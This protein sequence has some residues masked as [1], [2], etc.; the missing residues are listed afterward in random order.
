MVLKMNTARPTE[1]DA[2]V[3][4]FFSA[5][6]NR[7]GRVPDFDGLCAM[8]SPGAVVVSHNG[9]TPTVSSPE[10]FAAPRVALLTSGKLV[11]FHEW[12]QS[13]ETLFFGTLATRRSF[14][15][16]SGL[17]AGATYTGTGTK[18]FQFALFAEGWRIVA[19]SWVDHDANPG[20]TEVLGGASRSPIFVAP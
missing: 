1:I 2:L 15:S 16:K 13:S 5:F 18:F 19:L 9:I 4:R 7:G 12:E 6:D 14:Y 17:L 8:F 3:A 20:I 10:Q 11:E